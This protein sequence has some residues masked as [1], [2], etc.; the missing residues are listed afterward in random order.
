MGIDGIIQIRDYQ[1]R[2]VMIAAP[3]PQ[4]IGGDHPILEGA[5]CSSRLRKYAHSG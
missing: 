3:E 5:I 2:L 4:Q 1:P